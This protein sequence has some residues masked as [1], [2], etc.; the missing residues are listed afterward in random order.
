MEVV[1]GEAANGEEAIAKV[2]E[3]LPDI[4]LMDVNMPV[5]DGITATEIISRTY[6]NVAVVIISIQGEQEYLKKAM[7]AGG[8]RDYLVKP[9]NSEEISNTLRQVYALEKARGGKKI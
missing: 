7:V 9:I 8:A 5:M 3:L 4:V 6:P 1:G 2:A